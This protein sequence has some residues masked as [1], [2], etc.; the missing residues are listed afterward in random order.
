VTIVFRVLWVISL[1]LWL[2]N[3]HPEDGLPFL[4]VVISMQLSAVGILLVVVG[5]VW[6]GLI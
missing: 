4:M 2:A 6:F 1:P 3:I 5:L